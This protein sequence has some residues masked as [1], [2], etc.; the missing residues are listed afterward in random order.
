M[1]LV[2]SFLNL[3]RSS[4][5]DSPASSS[6]AAPSSS[7]SFSPA[8]PAPPFK[9][10]MILKDVYHLHFSKQSK[11]ASTF[12]RFQEYYESPKFKDQVFTREEFEEWYK[13]EHGSFSY[14]SDWSGFNLP[15]SVFVPFFQGKFD[16]LSDEETALMAC[17]KEKLQREPPEQF[18]VIGTY[19][20]RGFVDANTLKHE[21]AHALFYLNEHYMNKVLELLAN[22][23]LEP[24]RK[25]TLEVGYHEAVV[26][27]EINAYLVSDLEFFRSKVKDMTKYSKLVGE[28]KGLFNEAKMKTE[29]KGARAG[30]KEEGEQKKDQIQNGSEAQEQENEEKDAGKDGGQNTQKNEKDEL[31]N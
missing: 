24:L 19:G 18:Y 3:F 15:A 11:L 8:S 29:G 23:D 27:D 7:S 1:E 9:V 25:R 10:R 6:E 22:E 20:S 28:L 31:A 12:L 5:L 30:E 4:S 17:F 26:L 14:L 13:Q 21:M 16:P 2:K